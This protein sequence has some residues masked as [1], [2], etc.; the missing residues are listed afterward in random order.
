MSKREDRVEKAKDMFR[1]GYNCCQAVFATYCDLYGIEEETALKISSSFGGGIG[2]MKEVCG[3]V[4]GMAMIAGMETGNIDPDN[5][6]GK[7]VNYEMVRSLIHE[8]RKENGSIICKELICLEGVDALSKIQ[9]REGACYY[10]KKPC[11]EYIADSVKILEKQ[12]FS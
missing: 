11:I 12:F 8:F 1:C 10:K 9:E 4:C 5:K 2:H 7:L 6:E 3:A